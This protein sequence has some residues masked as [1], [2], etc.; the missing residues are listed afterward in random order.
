MSKKFD[1]IFPSIFFVLS[2]LRVFLSDGSK[3]KHTHTKNV[4]QKNRVEKLILKKTPQKPKS[5]TGFF[6]VFVYHVF[7]R[8]SVK[9]VQKHD[10][11]DIKK[12]KSGF[13]LGPGSFFGL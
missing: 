13:D 1:V 11:G 5:K 10:K 12:E 2:R 9:G 7:G 3:K 4:L 6:S 8:F